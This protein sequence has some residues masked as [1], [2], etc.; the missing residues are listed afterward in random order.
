MKLKPGYVTTMIED[1]Q[2]MV[3]TGEAADSFRGIVRSN[4]TAAFII[5]CLKN[6]TTEAAI[7]EAMYEQF[8]ADRSVIERD[9]HRVIEQLRSI[10]A[11]E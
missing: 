4:V 11:V 6:D 5:D 8:D 1:T 9:V 2:V 7:V 3:P 10:N